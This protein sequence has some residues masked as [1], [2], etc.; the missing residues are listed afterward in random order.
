M[1]DNRSVPPPPAEPAAQADQ[2]LVPHGTPLPSPVQSPPQA[3]L[4]TQGADTAPP[5]EQRMAPDIMEPNANLPG[6]CPTPADMRLASVIG[7]YPH[8][9][10]GTHLDGGI[11][12]EE[13]AHLQAQ[14]LRVV[15]L[16]LLPY[17]LPS[18]RIG[19]RFIIKLTHLFRD[20]RERKTNSELPLIF[21]AIILQRQQD[22]VAAKDIR[23]LIDHRM[24]LWEDGYREAMI[25]DLEST[26]LTPRRSPPRS[27]APPDETTAKR[28]NN[29]VMSG[30]LRVAVRQL[31]DR[32][33]GG[34]LQ[35]DDVCTKSGEPIIEVLRAK[36][37]PLQDP[38]LHHHDPTTFEAYPSCPDRVPLHFTGDV[39]E[40]VASQ[41]HGAAGP[42]GV[43]AISLANWLLRFGTESFRLRME[44]AFFTQ[45]LANDS[46]PWAA[47]RALMACRL[48]ALDKQPGTR[49]VGIGESFRRLMAKCV[50]RVAGRKATMA[51]GTNNLCAGLPAGIEGA[52]HTICKA[53][54]VLSGAEV[55]GAGADSDTLLPRSS[56]PPT[57][58]SL[59]SPPRPTD[60]QDPHTSQPTPPPDDGTDTTTDTTT[61]TDPFVRLT[62]DARNGFNELSRKALFWTV[63]HRWVAGARFA[64]NCYRHQATLIVRRPGKPCYTICSAEG[65][66]QG[67]PLSMVLYGIAL[68]PL[69]ERIKAATQGITQSWYADDAA[70]AGPAS[71]VKAAFHLL[72]QWGPDRGYHPE[73]NK[74]IVVAPTHHHEQAKRHLHPFPFTYTDGHWYVGGFLGP[75]S[76]RTA[77]L[78][79]KIQGW[80]DGVRA[81]AM[82]AHRHPQSAYV[83]LVRSLQ[84]E[85]QYLQRVTADCADAFA[86]IEEAIAEDFIPA[87]FGGDVPHDLRTLLALS[88][89]NGGLGI[90]NPTDTAPHCHKTS[91][92]CTAPLVASLLKGTPFVLPE[93]IKSNREART[94][95]QTAR[96]QREVGIFSRFLEPRPSHLQRRLQRTTE[97]GAWLTTLPTWMNGTTLTAEEFRDS[98]RMRYGLQPHRLPSLCDGC[99]APFS[100]QHALSCKKGG[101]ILLRHNEIAAEWH[102]LCATAFSLSAVS[103]EPIIPQSQ[104]DTQDQNGREQAPPQDRADVGCRGFWKRGTTALFDVRITDTDAPSQSHLDPHIILQRHEDAKKKKYL[105]ACL[106]AR[107]QFTPLVFSVD[108]LMGVECKAATQRLAAALSAKWRRPYSEMCGFVRSRLSLALVRATNLCIRGT[109]NPTKRSPTFQWES[110][111]GVNLYH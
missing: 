19:R 71:K 34:V 37:P 91:K 5:P 14:W 35:P 42:S 63:R 53:D 90:L 31:T 110:G 41:L 67:D 51:C 48:V 30:R 39:V 76:K 72:Q 85:W 43:D 40:R 100:L 6:Y 103:D 7:D 59:D 89:S 12:K 25:S 4:P 104:D 60:A 29:K 97:T 49:P 27:T 20:V 70:I 68:T 18:G 2:Q 111:A 15:Q 78:T 44:I 65:V 32:S 83:G 98:L 81:L 102:E 94:K 9:N 108:G 33:G 109:R 92:E 73:P 95:A 58:N 54:E 26:L 46:P 101:L 45:W 84:S 74:S 21:C 38:P 57:A 8:D 16:P 55:L 50:L 1:D 56:G 47:F 23:N 28:F 24:D 36:H 64:F 82:V 22:V 69:A 66:T 13:D 87:M 88:V 96:E 99:Q 80:V 62:V 93:Y 86:P 3:S 10:P 61:D 17:A 52:F 105:D 106:E 11:G 75:T 107:R 77:W 79:P